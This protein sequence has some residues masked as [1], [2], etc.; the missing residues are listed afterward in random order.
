MKKT[1][2]MLRLQTQV[3]KR[4]AEHPVGT[5]VRYWRGVREGEPSGVGKV[6]WPAELLGGHTPVVWIEDCTGCVALTH[7]EPVAPQNPSHQ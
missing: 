2:K 5:L 3:T 1:A 7:V 4:D 6:R